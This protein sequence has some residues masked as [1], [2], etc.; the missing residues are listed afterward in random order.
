MNIL[1]A[2]VLAAVVVTGL[3]LTPEDFDKGQTTVIDLNNPDG[4]RILQQH[5]VNIAELRNQLDQLRGKGNMTQ[6][7]SAPTPPTNQSQALLPDAGLH[8]RRQ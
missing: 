2:T 4:A 3:P 6:Q 5:N 1:I 7:I 8:S